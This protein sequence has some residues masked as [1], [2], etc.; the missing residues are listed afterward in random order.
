MNEA[1]KGLFRYPIFI[2]AYYLRTDSENFYLSTQDPNQR[3]ERNY[4]FSTSTFYVPI[5]S[6]PDH[7]L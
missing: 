1:K 2:A 4:H 3:G 5:S 7:L 6:Q